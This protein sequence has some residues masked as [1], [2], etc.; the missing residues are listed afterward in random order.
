MTMVQARFILASPRLFAPARVREAR[1][2]IDRVTLS[3]IMRRRPAIGSN[4]LTK[5][6]GSLD[7]SA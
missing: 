5:R 3:S 6:P 4:K 7:V 1:E 2:T